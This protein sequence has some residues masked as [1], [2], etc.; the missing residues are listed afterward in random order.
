MICTFKKTE[1]ELEFLTDIYMLLMV[2]K[3]IRSGICHVIHRYAAA[4][5]KYMKDYHKDNG[6]SYIMYL[7]ANDLYG[8]VMSQRLSVYGFD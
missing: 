6:S 8:W 4:N 1:V 3:G 2:E 7:N 5:N